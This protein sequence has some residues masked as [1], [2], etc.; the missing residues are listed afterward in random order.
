MASV[1][2]CLEIAESIASYHQEAELECSTLWLSRSCYFAPRAHFLAW[3][4]SSLSDW[5]FDNRVLWQ[6]SLETPGIEDELWTDI[7]ETFAHPI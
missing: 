3:A 5:L 4:W 1:F 7:S 2:S 6:Q